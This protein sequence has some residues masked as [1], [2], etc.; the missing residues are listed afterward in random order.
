MSETLTGGVEMEI[1]D[2]GTHVIC[3][4]GVSTYVL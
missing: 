4:T 3:S 1:V 2:Y